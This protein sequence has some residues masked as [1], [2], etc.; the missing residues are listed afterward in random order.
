M[1]TLLLEDLQHLVTLLHQLARDLRL[2]LYVVYYSRDCPTLVH[3]TV[4]TSQVKDGM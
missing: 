4:E 2:D 1:N 3:T